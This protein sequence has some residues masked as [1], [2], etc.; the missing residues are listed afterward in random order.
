MREWV[1]LEP[2]SYFKELLK[3]G[4]KV[5]KDTGYDL[6][7]QPLPELKDSADEEIFKKDD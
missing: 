1:N 3:E 6:E 5:E 4:I 7:F 2:H